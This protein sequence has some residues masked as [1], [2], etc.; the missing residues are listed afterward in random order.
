M[1]LWD[2]FGTSS[3]K[4]FRRDAPLYPREKRE[5][6]DLGRQPGRVSAYRLNQDGEF[7]GIDFQPTPLHKVL[8]QHPNALRRERAKL[9]NIS[10]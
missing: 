7:P 5:F 6:F 2:A 9:Y 4:V 1:L 10:E 3:A 8:R